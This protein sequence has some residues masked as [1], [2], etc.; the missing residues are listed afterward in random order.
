MPTTSQPQSQH[1]PNLVP[2][3]L[4]HHSPNFVAKV[5]QN[6]VN[7]DIYI[8][9]L[10]G[11]YGDSLRRPTLKLQYVLCCSNINALAVMRRF[12]CTHSALYDIAYRDVVNKEPIIIV[13]MYMF[14]G[15]VSLIIR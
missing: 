9:Q 2:T 5:D 7:Y 15:H 12:G 14:M 6:W 4:T 1:S 10:G 13:I 3:A 8:S 11:I